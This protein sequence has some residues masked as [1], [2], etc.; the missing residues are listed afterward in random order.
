M[1]A[2]VLLDPRDYPV[3]WPLLCYSRK[4]TPY[5]VIISE[6]TSVIKDFAK[7]YDCAK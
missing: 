4:V 7:L 3:S 5:I 1:Y 6:G 2:H